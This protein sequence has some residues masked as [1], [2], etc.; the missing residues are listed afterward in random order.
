MSKERVTKILFSAKDKKAYF[1]TGSINTSA[2]DDASG[3]PMVYSAKKLGGGGTGKVFKIPA[4]VFPI[5]IAIKRYSDKILSENGAAIDS[6]LRSLID[7]RKK[8]SDDTQ[9]VI[10]NFTLWPQRLVYDYESGKTS[11]FTMQLIPDLF[12]TTI[13]I[14]GE[15][16]KKESN[17]DFVLHGAG[18]RKKHGLPALTA[19][20]RAKIVYDFLRVVSVLH[21]HDYVLGDLSPKNLLIAVD[22]SNQSKNRIL[23]IDTDSYRKRGSIHPLQQLHTPDW[24]PPEC[25][26][27]SEELNKL[28]PNA[29]PNQIARLKVDM[30]IQNQYT[31]VYK[32]CLAVIRLYHDGDH[33]SIIMESESA[34]ERLRRDIGDEFAHYVS[35]GLSENPDDRPAIGNLIACLSNSL[36]AKQK[37]VSN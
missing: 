16:E 32:V 7:F 1:H 10:D 13:K 33:A 36:H 4:G 19:K 5:P 37:K 8:L 9:R 22:K 31:D 29:N 24:I 11:G 3:E 6:Y 15:E 12:Y 25:Q 28:T 34:V 20:G 21:S 30:F 35:R 14:A 23:F 26:R 17:L 18:F 2:G 27:A